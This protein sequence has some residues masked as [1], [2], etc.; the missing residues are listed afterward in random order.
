[1]KLNMSPENV[2]KYRQR[3]W[4]HRN[5]VIEYVS[6]W[7]ILKTYGDKWKM[8]T[9]GLF[10][11]KNYKLCFNLDQ[12]K[13]PLKCT[14]T[15]RG[16]MYSSHVSTFNPFKAPHKIIFY[17]NWRRLPTA[18]TLSI[19]FPNNFW[20]SHNSRIINFFMEGLKGLKV[21]TW[22]EYIWPREVKVHFKGSFHWSRLKQSL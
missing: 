13:L 19:I 4:R 11:L 15:S 18:G 22:L 5:D 16:Q 3:Q 8:K 7:T 10:D 12:W 20:Y 1:M 14:F 9:I 21:L 6:S 2:P 17:L